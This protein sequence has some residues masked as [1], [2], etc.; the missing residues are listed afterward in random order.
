MRRVGSRLAVLGLALFM[1]TAIAGEARAAEPTEHEQ[2]LVE[3]LNRARLD[4]QSEVVRLG[5]GDLNE[6][7]P[8][9]GGNAYVI[10]DGPHQP[11]AIN[12]LIVDAA[13]DYAE[14]QNDNDEL[15]HTCLGSW[16]ESRMTAAGYVP[17]LSYFDF[18]DIAGY[19]LLYGTA[20]P[21]Q[22]VPG[23]E[24]LAFRGEG[25]SNGVIDDLTGAADLVHEGLFNDF[26]TPSRGHRSTLL[27]GEW[28]EIGVGISQGTDPGP[29]DSMYVGFDFAHRSDTGPFITGV[30]FDDLDS[31]GFY[32]PGAG[33]ALGG[34][35]VEAH[36]AGGGS[37]A[38][39]TTTFASGGY[40]LDVPVGS[41]DVTFTGPGISE[42]VLGVGVAAGPEGIPENTKVDLVLL[43]E[44]SR[45]LLL[46]SGLAGLALLRLV[47]TWKR[48][49]R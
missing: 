39:S 34:L 22:F 29:L 42:T 45:F 30:A 33:E 18:F 10:Q 40:S 13:R 27:Y 5:T 48:R 31:D 23:R 47:Q 2:Y 37:L 28:K 38:D 16:P 36:V 14:L 19:T 3:L 15:C 17:M 6:G 49:P 44:P 9:L 26:A 1:T 43:P 46:T 20:S 12:P 35:L 24:N 21:V 7:P 11:V 25:P 8:T 32:T 41:Y 4:P